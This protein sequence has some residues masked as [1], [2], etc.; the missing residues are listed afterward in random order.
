ME[1]EQR[2][3]KIERDID[4][5]WSEHKQHIKT[6]SSLTEEVKAIND[7]LYDMSK[8]E[9]SKATERQK[10]A[11]ALDKVVQGIKNLDAKFTDHVS[12]EMEA[13]G[14]MRKVITIIGVTLLMVVI[15]NEAGT[16]IVSSFW[17]WAIKAIIG[18]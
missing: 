1:H 3:N 4:K 17:K 9:I 16:H 2:F 5:L 11:D 7:K 18:V 13:Y 8:T 10:M 12:D 15:D 6:A 14:K